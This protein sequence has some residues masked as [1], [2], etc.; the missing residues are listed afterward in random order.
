M[1]EL[2]TNSCAIRF[3]QLLDFLKQRRGLSYKRTLDQKRLD[4]FK[5]VLLG[6]CGD[7]G[8]QYSP[9]YTNKRVA[10]SECVSTRTSRWNVGGLLSLS[11]LGNVRLEAIIE[12]RAAAL[13][14]LVAYDWTGGA[15][16]AQDTT[17]HGAG[18]WAELTRS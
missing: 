10:D 6:E 16:L 14:V 15:R 18:D 2:L 3:V 7:I 8:K 5:L 11:E 13:L 12:A 17:R 4:V 9:G 1:G